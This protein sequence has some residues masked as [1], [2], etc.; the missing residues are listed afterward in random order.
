LQKSLTA[1]NGRIDVDGTWMFTWNSS[2]VLDLRLC[3]TFL[4]NPIW[5]SRGKFGGH[6][7]LLSVWARLQYD[8][9]MSGLSNGRHYSAD[10]L[11]AFPN[12]QSPNSSHQL[13]RNAQVTDCGR[14]QVRGINN[15]SNW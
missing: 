8:S 3:Q 2:P 14:S 12:K 6:L 13:I 5:L 9:N 10:R 1:K 11:Q 15:D 4:K 7:C